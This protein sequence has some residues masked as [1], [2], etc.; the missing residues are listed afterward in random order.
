MLVEGAAGLPSIR[1]LGF[2]LP[3]GTVRSGAR[4]VELVSD[5]WVTMDGLAVVSGV[6]IEV[7]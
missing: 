3:G 6:D 5:C 2:I 1:K 7:D 4:S